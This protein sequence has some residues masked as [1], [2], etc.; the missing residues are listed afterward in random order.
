ML[1]QNF[2][3]YLNLINSIKDLNVKN[4]SKEEVLYL[5]HKLCDEVEETAF[6]EAKKVALTKSQEK[7][8]NTGRDEG[9]ELGHKDGYNDGHVDGYCAGYEGGYGD[10]YVHKKKMIVV[11]A[12]NVKKVES[13]ANHSDNYKNGYD[14]GY[15]D[16]SKDGY[17]RGY[18]DCC[19]DYHAYKESCKNATALNN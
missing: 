6:N 11:A 16:G 14:N 4:M 10:G 18:S 3:K 9:Y 12:T 7:G 17:A 1:Y 15:K 19:Q 2:Q 13:T 5:I 8:Y